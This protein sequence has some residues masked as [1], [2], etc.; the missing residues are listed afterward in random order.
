M[1]KGAAAVRWNSPQTGS[2]GPGLNGPAPRS[3]QRTA[4]HVTGNA[5]TDARLAV[6]A[7]P[8]TVILPGSSLPPL[9]QALSRA[10]VV[11]VLLDDRQ[12][13]EFKPA[14]GASRRLVDAKGIWR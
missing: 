4:I 6:K 12:F 8:E 5:S 14:L 2:L 1:K 11:I 9:A 13:K 3:T 7:K 10:K